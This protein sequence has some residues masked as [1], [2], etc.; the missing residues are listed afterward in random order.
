LSSARSPDGSG[1]ARLPP[2]RLAYQ[3]TSAGGYDLGLHAD[4][5][6]GTVE[7]GV[8]VEGGDQPT[9]GL[10]VEA[11]GVGRVTLGM[12]VDADGS[13]HLAGLTRE[14]QG[15]AFTG[16]AIEAEAL[17]ARVAE[18]ELALAR[19]R[20]ASAEA[21]AGAAEA[22]AQAAAGDLEGLQ[23]QIGRLQAALQKARAEASAAAELR[24]LAEDG[25]AQAERDLGLSH[26]D[27]AGLQRKLTER[28]VAQG[29]SEKRLAAAEAL[30]EEARGELE[31]LRSAEQRLESELA[32]QT[33]RAEAAEADKGSAEEAARTV[34]DELSRVRR[35]AT[36]LQQS[37]DALTSELGTLRYAKQQLADQ[38]HDFQEKSAAAEIQ[39]AAEVRERDGRIESLERDAAGK[40]QEIQSLQSEQQAQQARVAEL[41]KSLGERDAAMERF[42]AE[43]LESSAQASALEAAAMEQG[44]ELERRLAVET[45][46]A[47]GYESGYAHASGRVTELERRVGAVDGQLK[48]SQRA[49]EELTRKL[50]TSERGRNA[51]EDKLRAVEPRIATEV[52][53]ADAVTKERDALFRK[54]EQLTKDLE[55][56]RALAAARLEELKEEQRRRAELLQDIAF[57]RSQ[58]ADLSSSKGALMARLDSMANR[59]AKRQVATSEMTNLLRDA[60]VIAADRATSA[61]KMQGRAEKFEHD[62]AEAQRRLVA[63]EEELDGLR[64]AAAQAAGL[65]KERD[66][67]QIQIQFF[68]RQLGALQRSK[69]PPHPPMGTVPAP[70]ATGPQ[71]SPRPAALTPERPGVPAAASRANMPQYQPPTQP[72]LATG[73]R[74]RTETALPALDLPSEWQPTATVRSPSADITQPGEAL[75]SLPSGIARTEPEMPLPKPPPGKAKR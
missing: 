33:R 36:G 75:P 44:A 11:P 32:A 4:A 49:S 59:E 72:V 51:A 45:E 47:T 66:Q 70:R 9:L 22:R 56:E 26:N 63:Q 3:R 28:D 68:Q 40:V 31:D 8:C 13:L 30:G 48:D 29:D 61:R 71:I 53:R 64:A 18:L 12:L 27:R 21:L 2:A 7:V 60:E 50:Q 14:H 35:Q 5:D 24:E 67:L 62:L 10:S 55:S 1:A 39:E 41:E 69:A 25:R 34:S 37:V 38:L 20:A 73:D 46:R 16:A 17:Q 52:A 23:G 42:R 58:V 6:V 15:K 74:E 43:V 57:I 19:E 65:Q 54:A